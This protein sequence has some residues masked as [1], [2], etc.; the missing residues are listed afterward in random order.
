M[1]AKQAMQTR[2]APMSIRLSE[3]EKNLLTDAARQIGTSRNA[4]VKTAAFDLLQQL[5]DEGALPLAP[6][7]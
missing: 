5:Q 4:L 6:A 2:P 1:N 7:A 3:H